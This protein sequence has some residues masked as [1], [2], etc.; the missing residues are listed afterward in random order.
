VGLP[1]AAHLDSHPNNLTPTVAELSDLSAGVHTVTANFLSLTSNARAGDADLRN[2]R[3]ILKSVLDCRKNFKTDIVETIDK[4]SFELTVFREFGNYFY[5]K[6]SVDFGHD[7][8]G[9]M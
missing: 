5:L 7:R 2:G 1:P 6:R 3:S 4:K 8:K 9:E